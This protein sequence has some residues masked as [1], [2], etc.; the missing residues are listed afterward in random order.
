[1]NIFVRKCVI[2]L[3]PI[4]GCLINNVTNSKRN[5]SGNN[6]CISIRNAR[7]NLKVIRNKIL[8][9][10]KKSLSQA[11]TMAIILLSKF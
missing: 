10:H 5:I 7:Y 9:N 2:I 3:G 8:N 4:T 11:I 1:M 6:A